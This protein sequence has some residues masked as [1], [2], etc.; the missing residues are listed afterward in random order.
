MRMAGTRAANS[1]AP[2]A[3]AAVEDHLAS[4]RRMPRSMRRCR[5]RLT[6]AREA[7]VRSVRLGRACFFACEVEETGTG[8]G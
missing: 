4:A 6:A 1:R 8:S 5:K 2:A 3:Y 7:F